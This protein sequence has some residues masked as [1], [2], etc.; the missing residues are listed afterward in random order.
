VNGNALVTGG[1]AGLGAA[2]VAAL[3]ARGYRVTCIDR[4]PP[5]LAD[6]RLT[7]VPAELGDMKALGS[8]AT[9]LSDSVF[10]V[11]ILNAGI[12]AVGAFEAIAPEHLQRVINVNLL[13]P[14]ELTRL[15]LSRGLLAQRG[16]LIFVASLSNRLGYPGAAVYAATKQGLEAFARSLR[17]ALTQSVLCVLPGPLD[18]EHARR[19]APSGGPARKR[20]A[21]EAL[22]DQLLSCLGR[23]GTVYGSLPQRLAAL[24][25]TLLPGVMTGL[26]R[27]GLFV[28]LIGSP[29]VVD[30]SRT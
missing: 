23:S 3:L 20:M 28:R 8:L 19:Y 21:P 9:A 5:T 30:D 15:L 11:A 10:D 26:M 22:A 18:T 7:F 25:G 4:H 17:P 14:I 24:A 6:D 27:R 29:P 12:S 2:L 13:A 16:S 1:S